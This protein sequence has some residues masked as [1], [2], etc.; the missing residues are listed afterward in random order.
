MDVTSGPGLLDLTVTTD[1][2]P[3][4]GSGGATAV[5]DGPGLTAPLDAVLGEF[6]PEPEPG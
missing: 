4:A 6:L 2:P 5:Y 1:G 3:A